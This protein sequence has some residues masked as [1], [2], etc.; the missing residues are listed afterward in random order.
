MGEVEEVTEPLQQVKVQ[1]DETVSKY[2]FNGP[3]HWN[4][5]AF[6]KL[7]DVTITTEKA[8]PV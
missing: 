2:N 5:G 1:K 3:I 4:I 8:Q 6:I 7:S